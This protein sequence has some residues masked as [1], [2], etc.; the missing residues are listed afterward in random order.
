M[1]ITEP[2]KYRLLINV[3]FCGLD[4]KSG[5]FNLNEG[6]IIIIWYINK[7]N[8]SCLIKET[9]EFFTNNLPVEKIKE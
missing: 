7:K 4:C 6:N 9:G 8:Y 2:G 1:I 5:K 3:S